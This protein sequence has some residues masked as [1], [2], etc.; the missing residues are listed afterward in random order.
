MAYPIIIE[1]LIERLTRLPG[2]GRRG[3]ERIVFWMLDQSE[4]DVAALAT[5]IVHIK[6]KLRFCP[7]TNNLTQD[8]VCP[9]YQN[10]QRDRKIVCIVES[11]KDLLAIEKT[12]SYKG[13]YYVLL[14]TISPS[15][16][17]G[18]EDLNISKLNALL[19]NN[20]IEEVVLATDADAEGEMTALHLSKVLKNKGIK[21]S[22]IGVGLPA[23]G[24]V[25]FADMSTLSMS[26]NARKE[27]VA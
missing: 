11:P 13:L 21:V 7:Y 19:E 1:Q 6:R 12:G 25:E 23:G 2:I 4:E 16:G 8:D 3:A 14:S 17:R 27:V 26:L 5:N 10:D 20:P 18:P 15:E 22:R 9:I 24:S